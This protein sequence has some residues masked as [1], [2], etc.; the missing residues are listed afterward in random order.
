MINP[1]YVRKYPRCVVCAI[2]MLKTVCRWPS[3]D[4]PHDEFLCDACDYWA[5]TYIKPTR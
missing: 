1:D 4:A 3:I 5:R 2:T